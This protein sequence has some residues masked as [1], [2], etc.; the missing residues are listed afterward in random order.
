MITAAFKSSDA[1]SRYKLV[2]RYPSSW[3]KSKWREALPSGNGTIGASVYG[4]VQDETI[5]INHLG[6][7]HGGQTG[8]LPD[9]SHTLKDTR[10]L[11][12]QGDY[13]QASWVLTRALKDEGY[14]S[15][16]SAPLPLADLRVSMTGQEAFHHYRRS[17]NME[18]GEVTVSWL[19][20]DVSYD[21][22]LF[23]SR[24][25]H[26]IVYRLKSVGCTIDASLMFDIHPSEN[27]AR[28]E[29]LKAMKEN[30]HWAVH[31]Q[32]LCFA[33][34]HEDGTDYGAVMHIQTDTGL[35]IPEGDRL[36]VRN[37]EEVLVL[38]K[39]FTGEARN[40]AWPRLKK[41]LQEVEATY[42]ELLEEHVKLHSALFLS[43]SVELDY[44]AEQRSTEELLLTAYDGKAPVSLLEKLWAYGRY[45][46]ISAT[47]EN[48]LPMPLYG[49]W[50]GDYRLMWC[51]YMANE[52]IQM[53]NWHAP[54]GGLAS[55]MKPLFRHYASLIDIFKENA[56]KLYGCRGIFIPAGTTPG[57]GS[58]TQ[59]VP[60]ILNWTGAAGWLARH[61]YEY[62]LYTGDEPFL[63]DEALPF[64][65]EAALFYEDFLTEGKD[66]LLHIY[67]SVSPENTPGNYMP[68]EGESLDHPMPTAVDAAMDIAIIK[69][70]F[71][72]LIEGSRR[73]GHSEQDITRWEQILNRL[74][75][76]ELN[77]DGAMKEWIHSDFRDRYNHRHLSHIYPVFPGQEF[78]REENPELF[79]GMERAVQMRVLG[80]Q[81]GWSLAHMASIYARLGDG[82]NALKS[83]DILTRSC[84][85]S[86]LF[87]V[88]ND[89]RDMGVSMNKA[90]APVQLDASLGIT[91]AIQEM[92][93]YVSPRIVKLLPALPKTLESGRVQGFRF[94]TGDVSFEWNRKTKSFKAELKAERA[95]DI[96]IVLPD[97]AA[98][99]RLTGDDLDIH[100]SRAY[101]RTYDIQM[102]PG[103]VLKITNEEG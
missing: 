59:I 7:W 98:K 10:R 73:I 91:N 20:G 2:T 81:T 14:K 47:A 15:T 17:L 28:A 62:Y 55:L 57:I 90:Q 54:V 32:F 51:H 61:Y 65:K 68:D 11:M 8:M 88:H 85:L 93:L 92:L 13:L 69:E 30:A 52:N 84:L 56:R 103:Q 75:A 97:I 46:Y 39:V 4:G 87:T 70:L 100:P 9:V 53:M 72:N 24:A 71:T 42:A 58:P 49:L 67:P 64:M 82:E 19:D 95:T 40:A 35:V 101:P 25:D 80:A 6:L 41:E 96:T 45:L 34:R 12:N 33:A 60:V 26:M 3:W 74:P 77:E 38:V 94:C 76:Y 102:E 99:Y 1:S 43:A 23:V 16:L 48:G 37:A 83:L 63:M 27:P 79:R 29:Q 21:R 66:G 31:G 44:P 22:S 5:L 18:T 78:T 86:N 50:G 36:R 89:W